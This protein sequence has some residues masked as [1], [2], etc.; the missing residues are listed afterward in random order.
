[1]ARTSLSPEAPLLFLLVFDIRCILP[2]Y[3]PVHVNTDFSGFML[4]WIWPNPGTNVPQIHAE[5]EE[6]GLTNRCRHIWPPP[7]PSSICTQ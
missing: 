3:S 6:S 5:H 2:G 1:M 4:M 7:P